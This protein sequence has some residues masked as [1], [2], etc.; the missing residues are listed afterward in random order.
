M[1]SL[2]AF[3][4]LYS[5]RYY[6]KFGIRGNLSPSH[7]SWALIHPQNWHLCC[8]PGLSGRLCIPVWSFTDRNSCYVHAAAIA[9][10]TSNVFQLSRKIFRLVCFGEKSRKIPYFADGIAPNSFPIESSPKLALYCFISQP[11]CRLAAY[12]LDVSRMCGLISKKIISCTM[13]ILFGGSG[14]SVSF[15]ASCKHLLCKDQANSYLV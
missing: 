12:A 13:L 15:P 6:N 11:C 1:H 4:E 7:A 3:V 14:H 8:L 9:L 5:T 2:P 10:S